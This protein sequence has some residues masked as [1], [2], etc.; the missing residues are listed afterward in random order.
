MQRASRRAKQPAKK[1][2][3]DIIRL[4]KFDKGIPDEKAA[5]PFMEERLLYG[6]PCCG[7]ENIYQVNNNRPMGHRSRDC[8]RYSSVQPRT[9][10]TFTS[11]KPGTRETTRGI[12][13]QA[14]PLLTS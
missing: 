5:V 3:Q 7:N 10:S 9:S 14:P 8:R 2:Q 1:G 6:L 12:D 13:S 4:R 11:N